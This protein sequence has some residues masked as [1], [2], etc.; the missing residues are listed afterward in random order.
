M[1]FY[2]A[3]PD[4]SPTGAGT[5]GDPFDLQTAFT[6]ASQTASDT[7]Y[8]RGGTYYAKF[9]SSL[10]GGT[11][12]SY[13]GEWAVIDGYIGT[14]LVGAI[15]STQTTITVADS[16]K[17][18]P[19]GGTGEIAIDGEIMVFGQKS[20][21]DITHLYRGA[22]GSNSPG[23]EAHANGSPVIQAG[24]QLWVTGTNTIY[25]D[26]EIKNSHTERD[27][28][29]SAFYARGT[30]LFVTGGGNSFI[31]MIVHDNGLGIF[32]GSATNNTLLYG[33]LVFNNGDEQGGY[34]RGHGI[35][36]ENASGYSRLYETIVLNSFALNMQAFGQT[37]PYV[38]GDIQGAVMANAGSPMGEHNYNLVYGTNVQQSPTANVQD[39]HF[40]HEPGT[41]SYSV[42]FGYG[43]GI[44]VGTFRD[45]YFLG[46]NAMFEA[47][48]IN[49][50]EFSGNRFWT[51][52]GY[53]RY[54]ISGE[55]AYDWDNNYY[56]NSTTQ[57]RYTVRGAGV[58]STW[59]N[60]RSLTGF[61]ANSTRTGSAMPDTVVVRPNIYEI[62]K[63][64]IIVYGISEPTSINV[65]LATT[66]LTDNQAY[67][68]KNAFDFFGDDVATGVYD[69][70]STTISLPLN[71]AATDVAEPTG[72][73]YTPA[74]TVPL[75][76][77]FV[78]VPGD[79]DVSAPGTPT[80][81]TVA[82]KQSNSTTGSFSV[83]WTLGSGTE[84]SVTL[85]R[86]VGGVTTDIPLAADTT[87]YIDTGLTVGLSY[88]YAVKASNAAGDSA[89]SD[90]DE[91]VLT[92]VTFFG[93]PPSVS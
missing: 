17:L 93:A 49:D 39:S 24:P 92:G 72:L 86:I 63:A 37:G 27:A 84:T 28:N 62:G 56:Y 48:T 42:I 58:A 1:T 89:W 55:D 43:S 26:F 46:G 69:A 36:L 23:A 8:L 11:V 73:G 10:N 75:F 44:D 13:P 25:R 16:S 32:T 78:V 54:V 40:Y 74:T 5:I 4:G 90:T 81:L 50:L 29:V 15:N 19:T 9:V 60:W 76:G 7:L 3:A 31:N 41:T 35:Y 51:W 80:G 67:T 45:N 64:N 53:D 6:N 34:G 83:S 85:R 52:S 14:T 47:G 66:G 2:Y 68:I 61:D 88:I 30:G 21:N 20:G 82:I 59:E 57:E 87:S 38:G 22:T 65:N 79:A 12:R 33:L 18:L 71:G 70:G 91:Q 77:V